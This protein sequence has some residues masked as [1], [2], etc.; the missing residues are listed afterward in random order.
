VAL[1]GSGTVI[2]TPQETTAVNPSGNGRLAT[3][4]TGDVLAGWIAGRWSALPKASAHAVACCAVWEH[5]AAAQSHEAPLH[6]PMPASTLI[7]ALS[8][9]R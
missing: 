8:Q 2:A 3:A 5:G 9:Q 1:K 4:G 6:Q 7:E